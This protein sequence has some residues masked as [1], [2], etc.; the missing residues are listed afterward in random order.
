MARSSAGT[1]VRVTSTGTFAGAK[2]PTQTPK[3]GSEYPSSASVGML[4]Q[5]GSLLEMAMP[6]SVPLIMWPVI[7]LSARTTASTCAPSG[8][9]SAGD[10]PV[11]G[12]EVST[13]ALR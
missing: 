7:V 9:D 11:I 5:S 12:T 4:G 2:N 6:G 3:N 8:G 10:A 1:S 13:Q